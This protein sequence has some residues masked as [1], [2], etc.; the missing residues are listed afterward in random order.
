M[1]STGVSIEGV[2]I[3]REESREIW[4]YVISQMYMAEDDSFFKTC[5]KCGGTLEECIA[6]TMGTISDNAEFYSF[7]VDGELAGFFVKT[8]HD[9]VLVLEGFHIQKGFR[10]AGVFKEFWRLVRETF[11][12]KF[13]IGV[14]AGNMPARKHLERN[15]FV[16]IKSMEHQGKMFNLLQNKII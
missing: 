5:H 8:E 1:V 14:L 13:F 11:M 2:C 4:E 6:S 10:V 12:A 3:V 7:N 9:G 15:G 16:N